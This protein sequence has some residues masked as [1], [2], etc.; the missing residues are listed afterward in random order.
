MLAHLAAGDAPVA[1]TVATVRG[2]GDSV[3]LVLDGA[4]GLAC[5]SSPHLL[6][7]LVTLLFS[8]WYRSS[9]DF[10]AFHAGLVAFRG[11]TVLI[12][13]NSGSG[14]TTTTA[15]LLSVG[16]AYMSD[17]VVAVERETL[18]ASGFPVPLTV[19][20]ENVPRIAAFFPELADQNEHVRMDGTRLRYLTPG[21]IGHGGRIDAIVFPRYTPGSEST[22]ETV[23]PA[24]ALQRLAS[25]WVRA[26]TISD[27]DVERLV[28]WIGSTPSVQI[29]YGS[30]DTLKD[31]L[32]GFLEGR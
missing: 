30:P 7:A 19:K 32:D 27:G 9:V 4:A 12:P 17:D 11:R 21:R 3:R 13:G 10:I 28:D 5:G 23:P 31:A 29:T 22:V 18:T 24:V 2:A 26:A 6:P 16:A 14:K 20:A 25:E 8:V 1:H 15:A